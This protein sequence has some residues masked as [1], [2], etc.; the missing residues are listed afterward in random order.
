M[1]SLE[2]GLVLAKQRVGSSNLPGRATYFCGFLSTTSKTTLVPFE[3]RLVFWPL[4]SWRGPAC[5][6]VFPFAIST[7]ICRSSAMICSG[8]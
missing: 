1:E 3:L 6:V 4:V 2:R 5:G 8:L 7:S